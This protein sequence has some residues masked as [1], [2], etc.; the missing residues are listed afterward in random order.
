M[1]EYISKLQIHQH[2]QRNNS[3]QGLNYSS[4]Q[5]VK[6]HDI[7]PMNKVKKKEEREIRFEK[8]STR[9]HQK[10]LRENKIIL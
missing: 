10:V 1:D 9:S 8:E 4:I 6:L 5:W 7:I 3:N 2:I